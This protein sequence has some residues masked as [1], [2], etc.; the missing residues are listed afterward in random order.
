MSKNVEI[1]SLSNARDF[2]KTISNESAQNILEFITSHK[3]CSAS[4]IASGLKIP[5]S[6]AHYHLQA[7]LK[8]KIITNEEFHYSAKGREVAHYLIAKKV[9]IIVPENIGQENSFVLQ[10]K[11]LLPGTLIVAIIAI[12]LG[13]K[14]FLIGGFGSFA[15]GNFAKAS[16]DSAQPLAFESTRYVDQAPQILAPASNE[17][18]FLLGLILGAAVIILASA[19]YAFAKTKLNK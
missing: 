7:L 6:T 18:N 15:G 8:A 9:I 14:K 12:G 19:L 2:A 13:L 5:A 10:L 11:A 16:I 4:Q 1:I 17:P 3:G